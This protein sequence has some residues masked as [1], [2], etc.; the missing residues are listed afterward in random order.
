MNRKK[1]RGKKTRIGHPRT[2]KSLQKVEYTHNGNARRL[3]KKRT[4]GNI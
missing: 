1:T 2:I 4:R 3:K